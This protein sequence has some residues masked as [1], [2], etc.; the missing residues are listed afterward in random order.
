MVVH[1]TLRGLLPAARARTSVQ[2]SGLLE[3][4][5]RPVADDLGHS[6]AHLRGVVAHPDHAV[7]AERSGVLEHQLVGLL[8]GVLSQF[9]V[10][11]DVPTAE[12]LKGGADA[13]HDAPRA[14]RDA[15][16]QAD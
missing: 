6:L 15:P 14:D 3:Y 16:H 4:D 8:A 7:G 12:L 10:Q 1:L 11:A 5:R 2:S 9:G 13:A